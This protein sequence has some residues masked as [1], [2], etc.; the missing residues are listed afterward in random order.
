M[1]ARIKSVQSTEIKDK[2]IAGKRQHGFD[3]VHLAAP[4]FCSPGLAVSP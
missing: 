3:V 4:G 1:G 2:K